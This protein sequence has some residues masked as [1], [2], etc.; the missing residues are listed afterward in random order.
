MADI[1]VTVGKNPIDAALI[2]VKSTDYRMD[3]Q[4]TISI[5]M[6]GKFFA[7]FEAKKVFIIFTHCDIEKPK[8]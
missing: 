8:D 3:I 5:K 1:K 4:Q 7:N 2:V 6:V